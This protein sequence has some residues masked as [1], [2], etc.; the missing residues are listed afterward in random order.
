MSKNWKERLGT[1]YSTDPGFNYKLN[2][3]EESETLPPNKQQL[4][5]L[6]DNKQRKGKT[7]TLVQNFVGKTEDLESLAK[8]LKTKCGVGGSAKDNEIVI[9]GDF[10]MKVKEILEKDG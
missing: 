8:L 1:V 10:K 7:V 4:L 6:T 5:V 9:Q 2:E 3:Q